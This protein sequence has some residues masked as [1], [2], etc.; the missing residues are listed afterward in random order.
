[1]MEVR[2]LPVDLLIVSV[3]LTISSIIL[4]TTR[5][6]VS[7]PFPLFEEIVF[8]V[9]SAVVLAFGFSILL[10]K[11]NGS[12]RIL[13]NFTYVSFIGFLLSLLI[14]SNSLL[15]I[16]RSRSFYVLSWV[17]QKK[18]LSMDGIALENVSSTEANDLKSIELRILEHE[19]RGLIQND[20]GK[21]HLTFRGGVILSLSN[22]LA[23]IF[24]LENW[25]KNKN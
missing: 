8:A 18:V 16:D 9:I 13:T 4:C 7:F 24:N 3:I 11:M 1:M 6:F 10:K 19:E 15:N 17:D 14:L 25:E 20:N 5:N 12:G 22:H 23:Q 2:K 21:Y